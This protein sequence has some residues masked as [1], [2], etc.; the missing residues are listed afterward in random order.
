M[1][2]ADTY[3]IFTEPQHPMTQ[4]L[5]S[6]V[7]NIEVPDHLELKDGEEMLKITYTGDRAY[8]P[9]ISKVSKD[10]DVL[11]DILHGKIEYIQ[12]Q[13]LGI[14]LIKLSGEAAEIAKVSEYISRQVFKLERLS[15]GQKG[16]E[17]NE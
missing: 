8:E 16:G 6:R 17:H 15:A 11:V 9:L 13:P 10:F 14:L 12:G 4:S 3:R 5:V 7:L 1:D 2:V